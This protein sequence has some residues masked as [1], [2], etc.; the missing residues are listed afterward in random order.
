MQEGFEE[1]TS[2]TEGFEVDRAELLH[3]CQN[4]G[5]LLLLLYRR[6]RKSETFYLF[7]INVEL[8][9]CATSL[10]HEQSPP[11]GCSEH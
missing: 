1:V 9:S 7:G 4:Y 8:Y 2:L 11:R 5:K 3:P 6:Q 10:L